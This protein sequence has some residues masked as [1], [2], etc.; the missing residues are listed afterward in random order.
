LAEAK[1]GR[2]LIKQLEAKKAALELELSTEAMRSNSL[3]ISYTKAVQEINE[4]ARMIKTYERAV[5]LLEVQ[6]AKLETE[7]K[8]LS[9]KVKKQTL[10]IWTGRAA[11]AALF[12]IRFL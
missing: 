7:N 10:E 9:K 4:L 11:L 6:A 2:E 12:I 3:S 8:R 1:A 5:A